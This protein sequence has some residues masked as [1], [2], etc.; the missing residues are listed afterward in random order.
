MS[1]F[2]YEL[3]CL[4]VMF[5]SGCIVNMNMQNV[6]MAETFF[7]DIRFQEQLHDLNY[8]LGTDEKHHPCHKEHSQRYC[9]IL[10]EVL[11]TCSYQ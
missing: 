1:G 8:I 2:N 11:G 5:D 10:P 9:G 6:T 7:G 3:I 4:S